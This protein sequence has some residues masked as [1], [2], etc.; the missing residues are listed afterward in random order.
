MDGW[1]CNCELLAQKEFGEA[2]GHFKQSNH[3][4]MWRTNSRTVVVMREYSKNMIDVTPDSPERFTRL[5]PEKFWHG[6]PPTIKSKPPYFCSRL[7]SSFRPRD[8]TLWYVWSSVPVCPLARHQASTHARL[9]S[10]ISTLTTTFSLIPILWR[11]I[12]AP[13]IPVNSD[14]TLIPFGYNGFR[15]EK[16]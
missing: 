6:L 10:W 2:S 5:L 12:S 1:W 16:W 14:N 8:I 15:T 4:G 11:A 9:S 3:D 13:P 7:R